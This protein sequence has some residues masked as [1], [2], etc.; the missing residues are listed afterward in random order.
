MDW[1]NEEGFQKAQSNGE[2]EGMWKIGGGGAGSVSTVE[3]F[4]TLTM[5]LQ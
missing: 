1:V 2:T 5:N 3:V 4:H